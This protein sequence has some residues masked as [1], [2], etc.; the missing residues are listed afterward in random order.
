MWCM[1]LLDACQFLFYKCSNALPFNLVHFP[2]G[3]YPGELT[4]SEIIS[5][6]E[7]SEHSDC[8]SEWHRAR[9]KLQKTILLTLSQ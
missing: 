9:I 1:N 7:L 5:A 8:L 2:K 4:Q 3:D 6:E